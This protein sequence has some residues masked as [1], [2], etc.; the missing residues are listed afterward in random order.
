MRDALLSSFEFEALVDTATRPWTVSFI[1]APAAAGEGTESAGRR[2]RTAEE[3]LREE[4]DEPLGRV[5][6][7]KGYSK[8]L[9]LTR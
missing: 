6:M 9:G 5:G 2:C 4:C 3:I 8:E 1:D 7:W